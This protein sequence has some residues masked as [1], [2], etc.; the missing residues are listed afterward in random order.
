M[1][2]S[3]ALPATVREVEGGLELELDEPAYGV[4]PGQAARCDQQR[5]SGAHPPGPFDQNQDEKRGQQNRQHGQPEAALLPSSAA[6]S[7]RRVTYALN[8]LEMLVCVAAGAT[9]PPRQEGRA[10]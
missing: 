5:R 9:L 7:V 6:W 1:S 10:E 3:P 4:A 8:G 2:S